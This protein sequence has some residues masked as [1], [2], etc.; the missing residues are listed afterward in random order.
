MSS[1]AVLVLILAVLLVVGVVW[2]AMRKRHTKELRDRFGPEYERT[3]RETGGQ[4]QAESELDARQKRVEQ[5]GIRPLSRDDQQRFADDWRATQAHFVDD[6]SAAI[7][8]ADHHVGRLMETRGYPVG[9][10]EQRAADISVNHP[11]VVTNYRAAHR[12]ALSNDE[13][14]AS[15]ENLRQAM[16]HY[17][18]LFVELLE[19]PESD[20]RT[21]EEVRHARAS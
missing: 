8:E 6:P 7:R 14:Q 5:L 9:D 11:N 20:H 17:R 13:G 21:S 16:V 10:F 2:F 1:E 12:I 4:G 15:T 18:A 3:L 19:L